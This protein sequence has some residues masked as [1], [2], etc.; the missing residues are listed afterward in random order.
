[1]TPDLCTLGKAIGG[2]MPLSVFG[3]KRQIMEHVA[4]LGQAQHSGTYNAHLSAILAGLAFL[5][6]LGESGCY[7]DLAA[8][9]QR[10]Y[11]GIDEIMGRLGFDGRVQGL[12]ARF[13]FL[14]GPPAGRKPRNYQDVVDYAWPLFHRFCAA[15]LR[16]GVYLHTMWHHGISVAHSDEDIDRVLAGIEAALKD[17]LAES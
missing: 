16:H 2:G 17:V 9:S 1:V 15:C 8:R 7:E 4:P 14:F 3:G 6:V 5:E 11:D 12:G 13:S 10:L